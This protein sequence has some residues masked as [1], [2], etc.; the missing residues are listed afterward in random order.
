MRFLLSQRLTLST[1]AGANPDIGDPLQRSSLA[2]SGEIDA[3][4][5]RKACEKHPLMLRARW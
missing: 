5:I 2:Y 3:R 4:D 1:L